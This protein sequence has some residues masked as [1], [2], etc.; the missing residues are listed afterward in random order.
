M[1]TRSGTRSVGTR[2]LRRALSE[3]RGLVVLILCAA[4]LLTGGQVLAQAPETPHDF[5]FGQTATF[6]LVLPAESTVEQATFYLQ[7]NSTPTTGI[8]THVTQGQ[9]EITRNLVEPLLPMH[10][11]LTGGATTVM[12]AAWSKLRESPSSTSTNRYAWQSAEGD[13]LA[14]HWVTGERSRMV[15]AV[16][17]AQTARYLPRGAGHRPG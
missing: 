6:A 4:G 13:G 3:A 16:D 14:V 17:V 15:Q 12:L 7:A 2:T 1:T 8:D 11:S 5:T 9:A 10:T